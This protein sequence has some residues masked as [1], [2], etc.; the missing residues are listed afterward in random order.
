MRNPSTLH[1][2]PAWREVMEAEFR[3]VGFAIR[4]LSFVAGLVVVAVTLFMS[5]YALRKGEGIQVF[6]ELAFL[7]A[8]AAPLL[9]IAVWKGGYGFRRSYFASLP[10]NRTRHVLAKMT[11]GWAWL[12]VLVAAFLLWMLALAI[13]TGGEIGVYMR[14]LASDLPSGATPDEAAALARRWTTPTWQWAVFFTSATV[15]YLLGS[16]VVLAGSRTRR[17]LAGVAI[18]CLFVSIADDE[19]M[20]LGGVAERLDIILIMILEGRYG[21]E[22]LV[23]GRQ[24][25]IDLTTA[26]GERVSVWR[27]LTVEQ[28][29]VTTLL[30][31]ELATSSVAAVLWRDR[32]N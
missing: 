1:P 17:W 23:S 29:L 32:K 28:W 4:Q 12:M 27:N 25:P 2:T 18:V 5:I 9:P 7:V 16:A 21:L 3:S 22:I 6:P 11:A 24:G 31:S 26:A 20:H 8:L 19:V 30:W 10:V 13:I 14:V 15:A